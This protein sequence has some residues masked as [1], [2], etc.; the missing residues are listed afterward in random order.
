MTPN[1]LLE[2]GV[3]SGADQGD[4]EFDELLDRKVD[5]SYGLGLID[6]IKEHGVKTP[7]QIVHMKNTPQKMIGH[8]HHRFAVSN[9]FRPDDLI[10]VIHTDAVYK[11][12]PEDYEVDKGASLN[13]Y[14]GYMGPSGKG[15]SDR[16]EWLYDD[17]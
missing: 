12:A 5:D 2:Y 13:K 1:E 3:S 8:G 6:D 17:E 10:P 11:E 9:E 7:V 15:T 16:F 14:R 4:E